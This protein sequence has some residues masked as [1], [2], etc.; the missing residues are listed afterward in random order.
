MRAKE[1]LPILIICLFASPIFGQKQRSVS[2]VEFELGVGAKASS[3]VSVL[4]FSSFSAIRSD[5]TKMGPA[6]FMEARVNIP[7][8]TFDVG[9]QFSLHG[10]DREWSGMMEQTYRFKSLTTYIDYNYRKWKNIVPFA[11]IGIGFSHIDIDID[12]EAPAANDFSYTRSACL[13]PRIGVE[14]YNR[15]RLTCDW[16]F[17][18][19]NFSQL[20]LSIGFVFGG[21]KR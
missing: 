12:Y 13:N 4:D 8:T 5:K 14:I 15:I 9:L 6:L 20:G 16:K 17:M 7:T 1:L 3:N 10:F 19:K 18:E 21:G 2:L 11:G